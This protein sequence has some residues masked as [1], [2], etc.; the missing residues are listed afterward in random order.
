MPRSTPAHEEQST[1]SSLATDKQRN[2]YNFRCLWLKSIA[3]V[4]DM[5]ILNKKNVQFQMPVVEKSMHV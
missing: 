5:Q 2:L 3:C 4:N 1:P